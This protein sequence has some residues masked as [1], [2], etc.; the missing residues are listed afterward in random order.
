M[1]ASGLEDWALYWQKVGAPDWPISTLQI[2]SR[3]R[4][5]RLE[6]AGRT[7]ATHP[8]VVLRR[9]AHMGRRPSGRLLREARL[10]TVWAH[11]NRSPSCKRLARSPSGHRMAPRST[12][13][14]IAP[15]RPRRKARGP[16]SWQLWRWSAGQ[17]RYACIDPLPIGWARVPFPTPA[18]SPP[19]CRLRARLGATGRHGYHALPP[20]R[21]E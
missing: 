4:I 8:K 2:H 21:L 14:A 15:S 12:S 7:K 6:A 20:A 18:S 19:K 1:Q 11:L 9:R 17:E 16:M 3:P 5:R 10:E 13:N